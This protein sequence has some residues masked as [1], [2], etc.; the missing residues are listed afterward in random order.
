MINTTL[1]LQS[2]LW[3]GEAWLKYLQVMCYKVPPFF[4]E[5]KE[6]YTQLH[7]G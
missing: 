7:V 2:D 5:A 3:C 4:L 6:S 1:S